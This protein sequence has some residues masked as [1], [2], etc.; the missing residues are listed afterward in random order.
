MADLS[1]NLSE[2]SL[3]KFKE[4]TIDDFQDWLSELSDTD[5]EKIRNILSKAYHEESRSI[6]PDSH[7]DAI[8]DELRRRNRE[9]K[10]PVGYYPDTIDNVKL[11]FWMGSADKLT[12]KDP[13]KTAKWIRK[14]NNKDHNGFVISD[15]LDGVSILYQNDGKGNITLYTRGD[16]STGRDVS[17][18]QNYLILPRNTPKMTVR[19]ELIIP[20]NIFI[21]N[22][23]EEFSNPR[24]LVSSF[25][26]SKGR[27]VSKV[28]V[29]NHVHFV[30]YE[31]LFNKPEEKSPTSSQ[32]FFKLVELGFEVSF[33]YPEKSGSITP[34]F[35]LQFLKQRKRESNYEVDGIIVTADISY[36]RNTSGNPDYMIAFKHNSEDNMRLTTVTEVVWT[37]SKL[38]IYKPVVVFEPVQIGGVTITKASGNNGRFIRDNGIGK[39]ARMKVSRSNDV[40]PHIVEVIEK[41]EPDLPSDPYKWNE[42]GV[43]L[44]AVGDSTHVGSC[45]KLL[46]G[47]LSKIGVKPIGEKTVEKLVISGLNTLIKILSA[48]ERELALSGIGP[49]VAKTLHENIIN[50]LKSTDIPTIV[51]ASSVLGPGMGERKTAMLLADDSLGQDLFEYTSERKEEF[52]N[53]ITNTHGFS[54]DSAVKIVRNIPYMLKLIETIRSLPGFEDVGRVEGDIDEEKGD[55]NRL[56]G[57]I[58]VFTGGYDAHLESMIKQAGGKVSKTWVSGA[59]HL[60]AKDTAGSSNKLGKARAKGVGIY[61]REEFIKE[62]FKYNK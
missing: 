2:I 3:V 10:E 56:Q 6:L 14:W 9:Y 29:N 18:L 50:S 27:E 41:V 49:K 54:H 42:N 25:T 46:A 59:T 22:Y 4:K 35:L 47:F 39:G 23:S 57:A 30:A 37:A 24:S 28:L 40:I 15:K 48:T 19:G 52:I 53:R 21:E 61:T 11:P 8:L 17:H 12:D 58:V 38:G 13:E 55:S 62:F 33:F 26:T 44:I 51:G 60:I 31:I 1:Q 45:I 43:E 36:T 5:L 34:E 32:Q 20:R 16:G 7:Y